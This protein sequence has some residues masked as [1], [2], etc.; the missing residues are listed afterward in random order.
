MIDHINM[1]KLKVNL[2]IRTCCNFVLFAVFDCFTFSDLLFTYWFRFFVWFVFFFL[3]TIC[4]GPTAK[5]C[6]VTTWLCLGVCTRRTRLSCYRLNNQS[7][8]DRLGDQR[9]CEVVPKKAASVS[10]PTPQEGKTICFLMFCLHSPLACIVHIVVY[11]W[12]R[13]MCFDHY[14]LLYLLLKEGRYNIM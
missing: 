6:S 5:A 4:R 9:T 3:C 10:L 11:V 2:H 12:V 14:H 13:V 8:Q 7:L 1:T